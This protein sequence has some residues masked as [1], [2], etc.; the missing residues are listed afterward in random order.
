M[1]GIHTRG[2]LQHPEQYF[3]LEADPK[4]MTNLAEKNEYQDEIKYWRDI[5]MRELD[6][7]PEGF[8]DGTALKVLGKPT[9]ECLPGFEQELFL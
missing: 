7:R 9:P 3:D 6:G 2:M 5:L 4:E 1:A 8:T